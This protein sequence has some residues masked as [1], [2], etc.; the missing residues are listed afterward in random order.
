M[1]QNNKTLAGMLAL[2]LATA[3]LGGLLLREFWIHLEPVAWLPPEHLGANNPAGLEGLLTFGVPALLF[4]PTA[5]LAVLGWLAGPADGDDAILRRHVL[6]DAVSYLALPVALM[7][8]YLWPMVGNGFLALG[9]AVL[10]LVAYKSYVLLSYLW[11]TVLSGEGAPRGPSWRGRLAVFLTAAALFGMAAPWVDQSLSTAGDEVSY[12]LLTHSLVVD[13]GL[14]VGPSVERGDWKEF[15]WGRWHKEMAHSQEELGTSLYPALLAPAYW[16]AGRLGVLLM[17]AA[18]MGLTAVLLLGW[19]AGCGL[20]RRSSALAV[21]LAVLSAPVFVMAQMAWPDSLGML[22]LAAGL[23]LSGAQAAGR[24]L[25]LAGLAAATLLLALLKTRLAAMGAGLVLAWLLDELH[26]RWRWRGVLIGTGALAAAALGA[27][28][29]WGTAALPAEIRQAWHEQW[30]RVAW[31]QPA[32]IFA[33]GMALD[34]AYGVLPAAPVLILALAGLPVTLRRLPRPSLY[35]LGAAGGLMGSLVLGRFFVWYGGFAGPGRFISAMLPACALF[36]VIPVCRLSQGGWPRALMWLLAA[37]SLLYTWLL[38]VHPQWRFARSTGGNALLADLQ[39]S[40]DLELFQLFPS[41][42]A[43]SPATGFW[44]AAL[45]L[46]AGG[47]AVW[48]WRADG[49]EPT[50]GSL[51]MGRVRSLTVALALALGA[52]GCLALAAWLPPAHAE[53]EHPAA[54]GGRLW[55]GY[56]LPG[57]RHGR[58]LLP[59]ESLSLPLNLPGGPVILRLVGES[60]QG[61]RLRLRLADRLLDPVEA[62]AGNLDLALGPVE[63]PAGRRR[64]EAAWTSDKDKSYLLLDRVEVLP[65][66]GGH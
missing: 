15:Y 65:S 62:G 17:N 60:D 59:G 1:Q 9:L 47:L 49:E 36:M 13:G 35:L 8:L 37:P 48:F 42:F 16:L 20:D 26:G 55:G 54:T 53:V 3:G 25:R 12:L 63:V 45:L 57:D 64:M 52:A 18:A 34:Q 4:T 24:W 28:A 40:L 2:G 50:F 32:W 6:L 43:W 14:E 44:L 23:R 31:W 21:L 58:V 5:I 46:G 33:K 27:L 29:L 19:L 22:V 56:D 10:G 66:V 7:I 41:S 30:P 51:G 61:G 38:L 11:R 39:Q